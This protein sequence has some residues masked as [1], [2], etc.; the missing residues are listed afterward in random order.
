MKIHADKV[1]IALAVALVIGIAS[2]ASADGGKGYGHHG[3][4]Y[5]HHGY[6]YHHGMEGCG[7]GCAYSSNLS[8]DA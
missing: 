4:G 1:V 5:G 8:D 6:G 2:F 7:R 3:R